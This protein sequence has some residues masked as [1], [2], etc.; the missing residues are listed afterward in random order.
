MKQTFVTVALAALFFGVTAM[1]DIVGPLPAKAPGAENDT[2]EVVNLGKQLYFEPRLSANGTISCNSCHNLAAGGDDNRPVSVGVN[3]QLGPRSAPTVFNSAFNSVQ[4]WDGREPD[5]KGQASGPITNP[6]E[7][8][9]QTP[10]DVVNRLK[11]IKG[12][13]TTPGYEETFDKAY[14][15]PNSLTFDNLTNAIAAYERTLITPNSPFDRYE[16]GDQT[17]MG[18]DAVRGFQTARAVGCFRC[19]TGANFS[20]SDQGP[21]PGQYRLFPA[22]PDDPSSTDPADHYIA[23]YHLD[24]DLG[25]YGKASTDPSQKHFF[26]IAPL[27]NVAVTAPYFHNGSVQ[28]LD[29]AVRVMARVQL[30]K[31]LA[32]DQ[33][34]DIV[35]FLNALTGEFPEVVLPRLPGSPNA[36]VIK[37]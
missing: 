28:T 21:G 32:P 35:A 29:E 12:D 23:T 19:H 18:P 24:Q 31:K 10:D 9:N 3:G 1:A 37:P 26:R 33:V 11:Q 15:A 5:L 7:M 14:G 20:G 6:I 30:G 22:R 27:R 34:S 17:A 2:A 4:F 8:G 16:N 36:T 25:R 13:A